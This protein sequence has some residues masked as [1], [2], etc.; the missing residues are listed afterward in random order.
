M[1]ARWR[2]SVNSQGDADQRLRPAA[3]RL[4]VAAGLK[5]VTHNAREFAC[6]GGLEPE[7]LR[8]AG[9]VSIEQK[10]SSAAPCGEGSRQ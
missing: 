2:A 8:G 9:M 4:R 5:I 7:V 3:R 1:A 6:I 10:K